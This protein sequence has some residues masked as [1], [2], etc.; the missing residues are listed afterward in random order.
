MTVPQAA[1]A[2]SQRVQ[3]LSDPLPAVLDAKSGMDEVLDQFGRP[4]VHVI[5]RPPGTAADSLFALR[6]LF[7]GESRGASRD[8]LAL[9]PLESLMVEGMYPAPHGVLVAVQP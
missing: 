4:Q 9:R 2:K 5:A 8:P 6:P 1:Q 3:Q 7:R